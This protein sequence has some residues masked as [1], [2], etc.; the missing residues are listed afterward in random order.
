MD[1]TIAECDRIGE[2]QGDYSGK[3]RRNGK[4]IQAVTDPAG[5]LVWYPPA[6]PGRTADTHRTPA[7]TASSPYVN[8]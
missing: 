4:N 2:V 7:S 3:A 6:L 5:K 8:E 1:D